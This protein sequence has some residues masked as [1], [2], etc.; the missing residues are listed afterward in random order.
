MLKVVGTITLS[1]QWR[2]ALGLFL[3]AITGLC[4]SPEAEAAY[5]VKR[6][7]RKTPAPDRAKFTIYPERPQQEVWGMGF[8][9]Q[10]DSIGSGNQGLPE[11]KTSVPHDLTPS[12][13]DRFA[14]D[15]LRGFRYCRIA[16][17]L[18]WRGTDSD[19]KHLSPR[20]PEQ[21]DEV[22]EMMNAAGVES[23]SF[24][25]W[26]PTP[27]WKANNGYTKQA[28]GEN[29]LR[30]FGKNF[31]NDPVYHGDVNQF[32]EDFSSALVKD[33]QTLEE[34]GFTIDQWGL[35]NEPWVSQNYSSCR[36]TK[37]QYGKVFKA[38]AP[39]IREHNPDIKILAD[40]MW[41][42][43]QYI[44]P[45]MKTK[46]A[47]YVDALVVHAIG[48]D[49]KLVPQ[50]F[51]NARRVIRQE[52]PLF[53]NEYEYL[54]GPASA[55]RCHN[56]VQNI[57]NWYQLAESPTWY[58][59]HPLKPFKN[60][61]ASGYSLGFWMPS[62]PEYGKEIASNATHSF[63]NRTADRYQLNEVSEEL[64]GTYCVS[65]DR[66]NG[67]KPGQ[68]FEFT[69]SNRC[70]VFLLV[71]ERGE[72]KLPE[73]WE[74]TELVSRW[75]GSY[76]DRV[77][78]RVFEPGVVQVPSH[79][80]RLD[81]GFYG[82]PHAALVRDISGSPVVV[83]ISDKPKDGKVSE[84]GK[85]TVKNLAADLKPG[86]WIYNDYNWHSVV[87][88]LKHMPWNSTV[89]KIKEENFDHDMRVLAFKRPDGKLVLVLSNR[90]WNDFTFD[91]DCGLDIATFKGYR[92]T[93][94]EAGENFLGTPIG[95]LTGKN[96]S[97][98]VPDM[99]WEFWIQQ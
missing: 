41:S 32:L 54:Q 62:D 28:K 90:C 96:I 23:V 25:Y 98:T 74:E 77:Y 79:T 53:Q 46:Y 80:G 18:Y 16:G 13:L 40:T 30:C 76:T 19:G 21:L 9:I 72:C 29:I 47:K 7:A 31:D 73:G 95:S 43:P 26:S 45:V 93:P 34:A 57:M 70:E 50:N 83:Q 82:V 35:Q 75:E 33:V 11:A 51:K 20:W 12:E 65:V 1:H 48:D 14:N 92:Y 4:M 2:I 59:I 55:A 6:P 36:Y 5:P 8:E 58:W 49:S 99:A 84:I 15:M 97:P 61:E 91:I 78:R 66:G 39:R 38:V 71:H 22:R 24:E 68:A 86:H 37:E 52:L 87:G 10:S 42:T 64:I 17:G 44:A 63:G 56:T 60:A 27:Y 81:N 85:S 3:V 69:I 88:F 89:V 94:D 67:N